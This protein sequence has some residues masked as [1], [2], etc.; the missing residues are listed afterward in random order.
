MFIERGGRQEQPH[1]EPLAAAIVLENE[2]EAELFHGV[3]NVLLA[4]DRQCRRR[5]D[6]ERRERRILR[7]LRNLELQRA[8]AVDD[9][10]PVALEPGEHCGGVLGGVTMVTRMR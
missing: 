8:L 9:D 3:P 2:R 10:A 6:V 1:A 5:L 4:D 7:D